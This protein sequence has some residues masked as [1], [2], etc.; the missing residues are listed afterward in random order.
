MATIEFGDEK[1]CTA[2]NVWRYF[3]K[4][5]PLSD[6]NLT[7]TQLDQMILEQSAYIDKQ[8]EHAFRTNTVKNEFKDFS[9][10]YNWWSGRPVN[11]GRRN[12][13]AF[14]ASEGDKLEVYDGN[15]WEDWLQVSDR[16]EGRNHDYWYEKSAGI[17][18]VYRR[19]WFRGHPRIRLTYRY[20]KEKTPADVQGACAKL[21]AADLIDSDQYTHLVPGSGDSTSPS[22]F[23]ANLREQAEQTIE[24]RK[25]VSYVEGYG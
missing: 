6:S 5:D 11:L 8:T 20:G 18:Y 24:S 7:Q 13:R 23:S 14:D 15:E 16:K 10:P 2:E 3:K 19:F 4:D 22:E 25:E 1:Y 21:V 12:I 17:L 9:G